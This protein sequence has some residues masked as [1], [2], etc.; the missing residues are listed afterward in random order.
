M[1]TAVMHS[2]VS[3]NG[4]KDYISCFLFGTLTT[5]KYSLGIK[6]HISSAHF[7]GLQPVSHKVNKLL[8]NVYLLFFQ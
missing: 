7:T 6:M 8:Q 5:V 2:G 4:F 1:S 3:T